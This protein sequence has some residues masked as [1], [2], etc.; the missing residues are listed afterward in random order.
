M[1]SATNPVTLANLIRTQVTRARDAATA[2]LEG[3]RIY[4]QSIQ[5]QV[6]TVKDVDGSVARAFRIQLEISQVENDIEL[7]ANQYVS[8]SMGAYL[9][10]NF[11]EN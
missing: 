3:Y 7:N 8:K 6:E 5:N 10:R 9:D 2:S 1:T 11:G 4:S